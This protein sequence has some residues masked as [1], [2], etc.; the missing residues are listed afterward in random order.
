MLSFFD[1]E[2]QRSR[3]EETLHNRLDEVLRHG[4]FILGPEVASLEH[5]LVRYTGAKYCITCANGTDALHIALLAAGVE[6]GDEVIIPAFT[7]ISP[8]EVVRLIGAV[9]VYVDVSKNDFTALIEAVEKKISKK[10]KAVI[11]VSLYGQP[12]DF[13]IGNNVTPDFT[14]QGEQPQ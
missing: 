11:A 4:K 14:G 3:I 1:Y 9:P 2:T 5:A 7:Y 6:P 12:A 8:V 13:P 10:T